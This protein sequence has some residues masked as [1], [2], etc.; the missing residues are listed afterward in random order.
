[1]KEG[2]DMM[3]FDEEYKRN[4]G[5]KTNQSDRGEGRG[6][7][8]PSPTGVLQPLHQNFSIRFQL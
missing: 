1:M 5:P 3:V 6:L 4:I 2:L 8:G 7:E